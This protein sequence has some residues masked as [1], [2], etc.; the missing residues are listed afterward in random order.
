MKTKIKPMP[1]IYCP[2]CRT[3]KL[4]PNEDNDLECY[5][6][7]HIRYSVTDVKVRS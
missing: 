4:F 2:R 6:C 5:I 3:G 7:G 1:V